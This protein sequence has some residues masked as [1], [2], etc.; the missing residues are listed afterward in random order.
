MTGTQR[1]DD[2]TP[3]EFPV[4]W[5]N[6]HGTN[7]YYRMPLEALLEL[8]EGEEAEGGEPV[9]K[10]VSKALQRNRVVTSRVVGWCLPGRAGRRGPPAA[11]ATVCRG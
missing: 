7:N 6:R 4:Q 10:K 3:R 1:S 5:G 2:L 11:A 9:R 8:E